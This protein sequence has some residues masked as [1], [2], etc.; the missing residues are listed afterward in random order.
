MLQ[1]HIEIVKIHYKNGK[2]F[3]K[4]VTKVK[5]FLEDLEDYVNKHNCRIWG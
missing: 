4:T 5:S 2:N 3:A 1:Q